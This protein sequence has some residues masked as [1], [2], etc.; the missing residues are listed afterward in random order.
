MPPFMCISQ[1]FEFNVG[2]IDDRAAALTENPTLRKLYSKWTISAYDS[3]E[4]ALRCFRKANAAIATLNVSIAAV[5]TM[6]SDDPCENVKRLFVGIAFDPV[7]YVIRE[8]S[9]RHVSV[10]SCITLELN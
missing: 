1:L 4:G 8:I 3:M 10:L 5:Q 6:L 7:H 2:L 9:P